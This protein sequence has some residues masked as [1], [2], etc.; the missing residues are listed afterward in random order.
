M[1][2]LTQALFED[3]STGVNITGVK[4]ISPFLSETPMAIHVS[5][6]KTDSVFKV[7]L[8]TV[9]FGSNSYCS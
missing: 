8:F 6:K 2:Q 9:L 3:E 7:T 5:L 4:T 1:C